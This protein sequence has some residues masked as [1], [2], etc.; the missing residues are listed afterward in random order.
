V[1]EQ[2]TC[3]NCRGRQQER[4][5]DRIATIFPYS[6]RYR[7]LLAAYKFGRNIAVG[8]FFAG[9]M[10]ELIA[11]GVFPP[12]QEGGQIAV[13]PVP[14]RPGRIRETGWDQAG[15]LARLLEGKSTAAAP[16]CVNRCL[17]RLASQ[18]QKMLGRERRAANLR[19]RIIPVRLCPQTAVIIDDVMTTGSTLDACAAA[20]REGGAQ[21]VYGLCLFYG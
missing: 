9:K 7:R 4:Q 3:L 19:G 2:E 5:C 18:N 11:S 17:R 8:N 1:S 21:R 20:L 13:V 10:L 15:Y 6:G 16:F 12:E 14:P